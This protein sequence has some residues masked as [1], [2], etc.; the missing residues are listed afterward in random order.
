MPEL[1]DSVPLREEGQAPLRISTATV[2]NDKA[3]RE[4]IKIAVREIGSPEGWGG[5]FRVVTT[6]LASDPIKTKAF[7]HKQL[8]QLMAA[9]G[10]L[11]DPF[12]LES[13]V[14]EPLRERPE[15][16]R[17]FDTLSLALA[18]PG[19]L[20]MG[21]IVHT[22][23][24]TDVATG[25]YYEA[26]EDIAGFLPIKD[27][28]TGDLVPQ[29][30]LPASIAAINEAMPNDIKLDDDIELPDDEPLGGDK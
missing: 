14:I 30:A 23:P 29:P 26:R 4:I 1:I 9:V 11:T 21:K 15:A 19:R 8:I 7:F 2:S 3:G 17:S 25:T 28:A 22:K 20:F 5:D 24:R 6:P 18:L 27:K 13:S 16:V 12:N 10:F